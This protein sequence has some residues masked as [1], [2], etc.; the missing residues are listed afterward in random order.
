M[1]STA[2]GRVKV[3]VE[4]FR[5]GWRFELSRRRASSSRASRPP[6]PELVVPVGGAGPGDADRQR[7]H[8]LVLRA[9]VPVQAR[10]HPG[11]RGTLRLHGRGAGHIRRPVRRVLRRRTTRGCRSRSAPSRAPS[12]TPGWRAAAARARRRERHAR[13]AGPIAAASGSPRAAAA[14]VD[15][16]DVAH[17]DRPQADRRPLQRHGARLLPRRRRDGAA[18]ARGAGGSRAQLVERPDLQRAVHDPRHGDDAAVR[19][20]H[21][22]GVR[23]LPDPA[24]GRRGRHGLPA[25]ERAVV[26]AVPVRRDHRPVGVPRRGRPGRRR[27]DGLRAATRRCRTRRR[28]GRTCGSSACC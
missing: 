21:G 20:A 27:L 16:L 28:P 26:L 6:D 19:D 24:P 18:D 8:P 14:R 9:A 10:R 3:D 12:S 25:P 4:A 23:E 1:S 22:R 2:G 7:R 11:S 17:D 5:W 15:L 13:S